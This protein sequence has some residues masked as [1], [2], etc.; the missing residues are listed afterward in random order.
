MV[1]YLIKLNPKTFQLYIHYLVGIR[2]KAVEIS[3][4]SPGILEQYL[5][6][7]NQVGIGLSYWP[8]SGVIFK[9]SMGARNRVGIGLSYRHARLHSLAELVSWYRFLGSFKVKK[10][11]L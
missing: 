4:S 11:G 2:Y 7:R 6:A 5:G 8:A 9:Q 3:L 1:T 10:F